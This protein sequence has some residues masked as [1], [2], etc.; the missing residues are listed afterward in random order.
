MPVNRGGR[1]PVAAQGWALN[2]DGRVRNPGLFSI[3]HLQQFSVSDIHAPRICTGKHSLPVA[4]RR[5]QGVPASQILTIVDPLAASPYVRVYALDGHQTI[6]TLAMLTQALIAWGCDGLPLTPAQGAPARLIIPERAGVKQVKWLS[7]ISLIS[8]DDA[9]AAT[10]DDIDGIAPIRGWID[11]GIRERCIVGQRALITGVIFAGES[12]PSVR[13]EL[14]INDGVGQPLALEDHP[15]S[16]LRWQIDW[17]P[18]HVGQHSVE[19]RVYAGD[20]ITSDRV[21]VTA[22][23]A[24]VYSA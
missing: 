21:L 1:P 7:R 17:T 9:G 10:Q 15:Q 2:V 8:A 22:Q 16:G 24:T 19:L 4:L 5:W 6:I 23:S 14:R 11:R 18:T 12:D 3:A 13:A 20:V